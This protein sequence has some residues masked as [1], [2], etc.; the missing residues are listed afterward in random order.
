MRSRAVGDQPFRRK[1]KAYFAA[2]AG[3]IVAMFE[4]AFASPL[5]TAAN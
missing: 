1:E 4:L 5:A 2:A 3:A